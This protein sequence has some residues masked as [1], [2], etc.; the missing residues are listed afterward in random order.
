MTC[1]RPKDM[2]TFLNNKKL[3][4][5]SSF[6]IFIFTFVKNKIM[7][8]LGNIIWLIFGGLETAFAYFAASL[9]MAVT[10]IGIPF[11]VQTFKIGVMTLWPFGSKVVPEP[12]SIGFISLIM[13]IIWVIIGGF[14]IFLMHVA[15]GLLFYITIIG[16]PFGNQH[17]KLARIS[18]FP[19]GKRIENKDIM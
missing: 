13:N 8:I 6:L 1:H 2:A 12:K 16:I 3:N 14:W 7:K 18:L 5:T 17:F 9:V 10:I 15:F 11:A 4:N 19:F